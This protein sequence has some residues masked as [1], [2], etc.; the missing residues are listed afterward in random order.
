MKDLAIGPMT[1]GRTR[2]ANIKAGVANGVSSAATKH[3]AA[4]N[5]QTTL[6][7]SR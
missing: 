4:F 5:G 7:I 3:A 1:D 2:T 6:S